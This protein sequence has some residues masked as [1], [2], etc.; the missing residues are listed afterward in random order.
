MDCCSPQ[1]TP[2]IRVTLALNTE[3]QFGRN[4]AEKILKFQPGLGSVKLLL[5]NISA[6]QGWDT[7]KD[8]RG[9]DDEESL[10]V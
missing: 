9:E 7:E 8:G 10:C 2:G 5:S 4:Q 3:N 1:I 6:L